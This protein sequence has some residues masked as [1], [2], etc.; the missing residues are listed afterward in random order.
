[1]ITL[2]RPTRDVVP[3]HLGASGPPLGLTQLD[4]AGLEDG[5]RLVAIFGGQIAELALLGRG[6]VAS[7]VEKKP[8]RS[9]SAPSRCVMTVDDE[10]ISGSLEPHATNSAVRSA[11]N[12]AQQA[13]GFRSTD[14][15]A[16]AHSR[17]RAHRGQ[18]PR[19]PRRPQCLSTRTAP[20]PSRSACS[21]EHGPS[22]SRRAFA[23]CQRTPPHVA[24][25]S[26]VELDGARLTFP[27]AYP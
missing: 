22:R 10:G 16:A 4:Q 26:E 13:D 20:R 9:R 19:H 2:P 18:E 7:D 23:F 6:E 24:D 17:Q 5:D 21:A 25:G 1:M 12:R 27:R 14:P 15:R 11:A 8:S 3:R